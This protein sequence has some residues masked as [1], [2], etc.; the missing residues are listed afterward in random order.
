MDNARRTAVLALVK[1]EKSGY[2][3]IVLSHVL[4]GF[5]G[6]VRDRAFVSAL[7]YGTL[8]RQITLDYLLNPL[9][10]KPITKMDAE[11]RA[12]L[13]CGLYQ[14]K[15]M[16][17]VPRS[18]AV[19]ESVALTRALGKTSAQGLVNAV[20]RKA[21]NANIEDLCFNTEE[22]RLG[23]VYSVSQSVAAVFIKAYKNE[24]ACQLAATLVPPQLCIRV[25][26]MIATIEELEL[27]YHKQNIHTKRGAVK[28]SLYVEYKGDITATKAFRNGMFHVEGE[29]SQLACAA[30][31]PKQGCKVIDLCAAPG[32]KSATL[33]Q[34][35][36]NEGNLISADIAD[37]R[38]TLIEELL[39]RN[40]VKCAK[41]VQNDAAVFNESFCDA[42][43]VLCDVPCSGLGILSKKP[44]I[45][46][47]NLED[48]GSLTTLQSKILQT[49]SSYVKKGGALVYSTCTVNPEENEVIVNTFLSENKDF[50]TCKIENVP[51]GAQISNNTVSFSPFYSK[52]DGFF[53]ASFER[54]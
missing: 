11:V 12:I 16:S 44:D 53:V 32:G 48:L 23:A 21:A 3:N 25:N 37:N 7:F 4:E 28:G 26:T 31:S 39:T 54:L 46:Q 10:K 29:A 24:A 42:D 35:M 15:Y 13:R 30:L 45:R 52:L 50:K 36:Q 18:A 1:Q 19:N 17:T 6:D 27:L 49:A 5:V 8:E 33:A 22:E 9:L 20:L 43:Y 38:L 41:V 34:Y 47:K 40:G 14:A 2:A 51:N